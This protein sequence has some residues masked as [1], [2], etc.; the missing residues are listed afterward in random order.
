MNEIERIIDIIE[1][2]L[3]ENDSEAAFMLFL[4]HITRL[5]E[6]D[7]DGFIMHFHKYF[8]KKYA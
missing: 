7:R 6:L 2:K 3:V 5:S 4:L 8:R 1:K